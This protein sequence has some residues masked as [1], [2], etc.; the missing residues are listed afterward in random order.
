MTAV[1]MA[2]SIAVTGLSKARWTASGVLLLGCVEVGGI[3]PPVMLEV[4]L[5]GVCISVAL[6]GVGEPCS[7]AR[8]CIGSTPEPPFV[9]A[10]TDTGVDCGV[11]ASLAQRKHGV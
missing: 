3:R 7:C 5:C 11:G 6:D 4:L 8:T 2:C 9:S 1:C 10:A